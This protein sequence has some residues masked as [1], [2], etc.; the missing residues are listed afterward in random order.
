MTTMI[1]V[2]PSLLS[3]IPPN[4]HVLIIRFLTQYIGEQDTVADQAL[5]YPLTIHQVNELSYYAPS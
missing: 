3:S 4:Q 5:G 2:L 1:F